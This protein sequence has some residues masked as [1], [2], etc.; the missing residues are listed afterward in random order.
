MK[1]YVVA[2][3]HG[4]FTELKIA[5]EKSG[6]F[7]DSKP[8]KLV[9]CGDLLDRGK[10]ANELI[11]FM[12]E[13]VNKDQLVY[14]RGNHEDLFNQC[15]HEIAVKGTGY[16][17]SSG[18]H[19]YLNGT[20]DAIVQISKMDLLDAIYS[21][22]ELVERVKESPFYQTL[23]PMSLDYFE[24]KNYVFVHGW[25]PCITYGYA[26]NIIYES[27]EN[28]RVDSVELWK[29]A[30]WINGMEAWNNGI[31]D[32]EKVIVCGHWHA[33]Y[34]H[35]K[36]NNNGSEF[37]KDACFDPFISKGIIALDACTAYSNRVNCVIIEDENL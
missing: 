26:P 24:T 18:S 11:D 14:I 21:P 37:G 28:W 3:V 30:R 32:E 16:V 17:V 23:L 19:H 36:I 34:G 27:L 7:E 9:V 8:H 31:K 13:L 22:T 12:M 29:K 4:Y 6:F 5:L 20:W 15:L 2:D 10:E 35:S 33:S 25:I 1:Y